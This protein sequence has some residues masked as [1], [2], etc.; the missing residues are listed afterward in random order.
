VNDSS[1]PAKLIIGAGQIT[2]APRKTSPHTKKHMEGSAG[3]SSKAS[4]QSLRDIGQMFVGVAPPARQIEHD[5][6]LFGN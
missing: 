3:N 2:A 1:V 4:S 5:L 6:V